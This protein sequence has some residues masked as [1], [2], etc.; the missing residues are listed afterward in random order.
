MLPYQ[1]LLLPCLL[2]P[3]L[4]PSHLPPRCTWAW[5]L[6][7]LVQ[8]R[9]AVR[10]LVVLGVAYSSMVPLVVMVTWCMPAYQP[11]RVHT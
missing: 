2:H 10:Y 4:L 11:H 3:T 6:P 7:T 5:L 9:M 8:C 1:S